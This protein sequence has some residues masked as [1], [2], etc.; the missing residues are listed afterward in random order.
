MPLPELCERDAYLRSIRSAVYPLKILSSMLLMMVAM[1]LSQ[2][3]AWLYGRNFLP[4]LANSNKFEFASLFGPGVVVFLVAV[5][6]IR[7]RFKNDVVEREVK[8]NRIERQSRRL[9]E[10]L[11]RLE[12]L[13]SADVST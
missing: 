13:K 4:A 12:T 10:R 1:T 8:E 6:V 5:T 7:D 9:Q 2:T 3:F 11:T